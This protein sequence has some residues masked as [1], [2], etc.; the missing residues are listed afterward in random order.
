MKAKKKNKF[1]G[2]YLI[3]FLFLTIVIVGCGKE[4]QGNAR[5]YD[6][7]VKTDTLRVGT[8]YASTSFFVLREDS[9]G[10]DYELVRKFCDD[11]SLTLDLVTA[12]SASQ[13]MMMLDS[14]K[15]DL[16]A[17]RMPETKEAKERYLFVDN[18]YVA[19]QVL[20]QRRGV[21]NIVH[22]VTEL[23]GKRVH[24]LPHSKYKARLENLNA[25]LGGGIE[26]VEVG[27]TLTEDDL[28]EMV[29]K[30]SIDFTVAEQDI[31][32]MSSTY[33]RNIDCALS[34]SFAQR[35]S[36]T[37]NVAATLLR[38][39][40]NG[41]LESQRAQEYYQ[42]LEN[43]Y[44]VQA[45]Y[46]DDKVTRVPRGAISPYDGLFKLFGE[47]YHFSWKLLAAVAHEES[48]FDETVVSWMGARGVMQVMPATARH[49]GVDPSNL[50]DPAENIQL[51]CRIL[52]AYERMFRSV[53]DSA[54]RICYVL[55]AYN[56]GPAHV[57]DAMALADK[58]GGDP[59][60]WSDTRHYL[61]LKNQ[62]EYYTDPVV[63]SG[64]FR[65]HRTIEY[66]EDVLRTYNRYMR[67]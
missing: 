57:M 15:I 66:V 1:K 2:V 13:L 34:V 16:V 44:F 48:H 39:T 8:M 62:K 56:A 61:L 43:K 18:K 60:L 32:R 33:Y 46:F 10:F 52:R 25:E 50:D 41:W 64:F 20:V 6:D 5:D 30:D 17:Y 58:Y 47:K 24:V 65:A 59:S 26:I 11:H 14:G 45:K 63:R 54:Q 37:L 7:I 67:R 40:L 4:T 35:A 29:A 36:W 55:A 42:Q 12:T 49:Y 21:R 23:I 19:S 22:N 51:G 31:A 27:D 53:G 9:L 38:D 28:I 3:L